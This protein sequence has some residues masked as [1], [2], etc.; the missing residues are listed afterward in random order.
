MKQKTPKLPDQFTLQET[1]IDVKSSS[2]N[3]YIVTKSSCTCIG[4]SFHRECRHY[5]QARE[6]G[7]IEQ[8]EKQREKKLS[9]TVSEHARV[10]RKEAIRQFLKKKQVIFT[11]SVIDKI[12]KVMTSTTKPE[13]VLRMVVENE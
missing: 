7:L 3:V 5:K 11:E 6:L 10:L 2:G 9:I 12:E 4:Y 8:L 1:H 13:D